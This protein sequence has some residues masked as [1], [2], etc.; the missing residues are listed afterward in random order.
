MIRVQNRRITPLQAGIFLWAGALFI[1]CFLVMYLVF[2]PWQRSL[3]SKSGELLLLEARLQW[4]G[5]MLE[6]TRDPQQ[7]MASLTRT[8]QVLERQFPD[9]ESRSLVLLADYANK[10]RVQ[11]EKARPDVAKQLFRDVRGMPVKVDRKTCYFL[12]VALKFKSGY[13][14]WMKYCEILRRVMPAY[15]SIE[16]LE[17]EKSHGQSSELTGSADM[18]LFLLE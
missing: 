18:A 7:V 13:M 5:E 8:K 10:F 14:N 17:L 16:R 2:A 12:H 11:I 4:L 9:T 1:G 15:L 3:A 6:K